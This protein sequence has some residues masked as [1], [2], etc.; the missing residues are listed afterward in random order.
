MRS[1]IDWVSIVKWHLVSLKFIFLK[2]GVLLEIFS[3]VL[4]GVNLIFKDELSSLKEDEQLRDCRFWILT[5]RSRSSLSV[6]SLFNEFRSEM[7]ILYYF[8]DKDRIIFFD[9]F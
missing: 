7:A 8:A 6:V 3:G 9:F 2:S 4:K 1:S 5:L